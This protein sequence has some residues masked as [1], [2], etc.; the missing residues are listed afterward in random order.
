MAGLF[1]GYCSDAHSM[2][3]KIVQGALL[4]LLGEA[5]LS[6]MGAIIKHLSIELPTEVVV[7]YRNLFGLIM[8]VPIILHAG[9]GTL[10]TQKLHLHFIR[11]GVGLSAMYGFFYVIANMPLAEAFLVKLTTPLFMPIVAAL[12]LGESIQSKT[13]W[14]IFIGFLG[15]VFILRP[16]TEAF[17]PIALIG[18]GAAFLASTAK[19]TIRK[20][21][22]TEPSVRIVFY[23]GVISSLLSAIPLTW[24][25]QV[26]E[27]HHWPWIALMGLV[28]TLGQLALTRAY[29]IA[30]PGQIGPY[31]YSS[32]LYGALLGYVFWGEHLL[33]TTIIGSALIIVAGIWNLKPSKTNRK[34]EL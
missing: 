30:K 33:V 14:A 25:W 2:P 6:I 28:G 11:A 31:V 10:K 1:H 4:I 15:V 24:A 8:L 22:S 27:A 26:P 13:R 34:Q 21:G 29:R 19:V 9:P 5:L 23:F 12:W 16:G 32:V 17:T 7:F 3:N 18:I 20:M